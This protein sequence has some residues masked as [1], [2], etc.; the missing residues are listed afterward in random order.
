MF[1]VKLLIPLKIK[2]I[3]YFYEKISQHK[4]KHCL[5]GAQR[6]WD[7]LFHF[8]FLLNRLRRLG[9]LL[10]I[11]Y[12]WTIFSTVTWRNALWSTVFD[13]ISYFILLRANKS[14]ECCYNFNCENISSFLFH[15]VIRL[16][17]HFWLLTRF[18]ESRVNYSGWWRW[19]IYF[20][21]IGYDK[22]AFATFGN[23]QLNLRYFVL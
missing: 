5:T 11:D 1:V 7:F 6:S 18:H 20:D 23:F 14:S 8:N 15:H 12:E 22:V 17:V 9:G 13:S 19:R 4:N 3:E 2:T 16:F 10:T 21:R